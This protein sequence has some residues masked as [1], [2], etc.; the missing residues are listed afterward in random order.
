ML[1]LVAGKLTAYD[2]PAIEAK[3]VPRNVRRWALW[4][5]WAVVGSG[6]AI[7]A[8]GMVVYAFAGKQFAAHDRTVAD[9]CGDGCPDVQAMYPELPRQKRHAENEQIVAFSLLSV[10]GAVVIAGLIGVIMNQARLQLEPGLPVPAIALIPGG[11][12]A[13]A[14]WRF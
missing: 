10:G 12:Q 14:N 2:I 7:G 11:L 8:A 4:K 3:A 1:V 5:P 13:S 9:K 6:A